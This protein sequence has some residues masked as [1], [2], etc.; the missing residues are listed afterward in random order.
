MGSVH[1]VADVAT[2]E[3]FTLFLMTN[4]DVFSCG[5]GKEGQLGTELP[6][7]CRSIRQPLHIE[8]L[9]SWRISRIACGAKHCIA[10]SQCGN[11]FEWGLLL[12][13][14][15]QDEDTFVSGM[16][17][18]GRNFEEDLNTREQRIIAAS[19]RE[20]L[21]NQPA[22]DAG[23]DGSP[24][25][26]FADEGIEEFM[27]QA[28]CH[29]HPVPVPQMCSGIEGTR[30]VSASCGWAHSAILG[31]E[32]SVFTCG[33]NEKGQLGNGTRLPSPHFSCI[34]L[35]SDIEVHHRVTKLMCGANHTAAIAEPGGTLFT[36]GLGTFGQ[37]GLGHHRKESC[38]PRLV[39]LRA[40]VVQVACG[41]NHTI[42]LLE[43]GSVLA[44]GHRDA[45]GG[46]SHV[47]R[48]PEVVR[49]LR[50]GTVKHIFAG[51][52]G[53][54]AVV[55][56]EE[57]GLPHA[58]HSWGYNQRFQLGRY[59]GE[60]QLIRPGPTRVP[61]LAGMAL[62][63]LGVGPY[64]C[65]ALMR[66]P[67]API[68]PPDLDNRC[69]GNAALWAML[70]AE[71]HH[72]VIIKAA[73]KDSI[74]ANRCVLLLRCPALASR[75]KQADENAYT[76]ATERWEVDLS[77]HRA[78]TIVAL[79][80]YIYGDCC[81]ASPDVAASLQSLAE[82]LSL[83]RLVENI[84]V[85]TE[86]Q[87]SGSGIRW[88]RTAAGVWAEVATTERAAI[89]KSTPSTYEHDLSGLV[90]EDGA[91]VAD[92]I[93]LHVKQADGTGAKSVQVA[94]PLLM[95]SPFFGALLDGGFSEA[96]DLRSGSNGIEVCADNADA[97]VLCL[98]TFATGNAQRLMPES[99]HEL[100]CVMVEAHRLG[101]ADALGAAE[102]KLSRAVREGSL[103]A[104]SL[105]TVSQ[106]AKLFD[107]TRLAKEADA[108]TLNMQSGE[109]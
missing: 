48:L 62:T 37:L 24:V 23:D 58:L 1:S 25:A 71:M 96:R 35:H 6:A 82:N 98:R 12:R 22:K 75:L 86:T 40:A 59:T 46:N 28:G 50:P 11:A 60:L 61:R 72:D 77:E 99:S 70:D 66:A 101:F 80:E 84:S 94:R 2:G 54:F 3:A 38:A 13:K 68:L 65:V 16:Q 49:S 26:D 8:A 34:S 87:S 27:Q 92:Y 21:T 43:G 41:T 100:L 88:M 63:N 55:D 56:D 52:E 81:C 32:G 47:E 97:F 17:G 33:Y 89:K 44:F 4:G 85:A 69:Y 91:A 57:I 74:G 79:L 107:M 106:A 19:W 83:T 14:S 10:V 7:G 39:E 5:R 76:Y 93:R 105:E 64:H 102:L 29:R 103:D 45:L 53:N 67:E 73:D 31:H 20:Y 51:G 108:R 18:L 104:E 109:A 30:I 9:E 95:A 15:P 90:A 78:V 36:W 42:T